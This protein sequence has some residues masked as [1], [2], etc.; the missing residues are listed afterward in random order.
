MEAD[1]QH[2][3]PLVPRADADRAH[4]TILF[5]GALVHA[6]ASSVTGSGVNGEIACCEVFF[7]KDALCQRNVITH[8]RF[9]SPGAQETTRCGWAA[10]AIRP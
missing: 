9:T 5:N 1:A 3:G 4:C 8:E 2:L 6:I 10:R 7:G